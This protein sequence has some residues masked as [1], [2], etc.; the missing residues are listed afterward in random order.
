MWEKNVGQR[1]VLILVVLLAALALIRDP[2]DTLRPGLDIAGGVSLVFEI[3]DRGMENHPNLAEDMKRLLQQRV[4]PKGV[5]DLT[6]RVHGRN[7]IE[8]Q[9]PLP[10][11]RVAELRRQYANALDDLFAAAVTRG[12]LEEALAR[13]AANRPAVLDE[14]ARGSAERRML[15]VRAAEAY[16][17]YVAALEAYRA[18]P[19]EPVP[20]AA[21]A[22]PD[23]PEAAAAP[24][25]AKTLAD[26]EFELRDAEEALEDAYERLLATN[27][28]R[29]H[30][31]RLLEMEERTQKRD[32]G[33]SELRGKYPELADK[34]NAAVVAH[35]AWRKHRTQLD[36]PADLQRLVRGAGVLEFRILLRPD[37]QNP[38]EF[39]SYRADLA[40]RGPRPVPGKPYGWFKVDN[41]QNFFGLRTL[42][43]VERF[44]PRGDPSFVAEKL[45][46]DYYVLAKLSPDDGLL[47][48]NRD[49]Q[50]QGARPDRDE[51]GRPCVHFQLDVVGG[52]RF[53]NLTRRNIGQPLGILMDDIAYSAPNI[54]TKIG[55]QG[56]IT[57]EFSHDKVNYL[58]QTMNAG[59][60]PARLKDT[61]ISER[62]IGSSLGETNLKLAFRAGVVGVIVVALVMAVYYMSSG[63]VA[64]VALLLNIVLVLAVM[65]L[66]QARLTLAGIAGIILTI[67]MSVDAN[68]LIFERMREERERGS[69]L[70]L[71]IKNGYEKALSTIV[72]ANITTMLTCVILF[73]VGSEEIKGFGLTLGW[74]IVISMF[75]ALFVTRTIFTLLIKYG[76]L[77]SVPMLR[78]IG[79]P[80]VDWYA[81]R[82][83]FIPLSLVLVLVG[84]GLLYERGHRNFLDVE[85]LGGV[86]AE[87]ELRPAPDGTRTLDDV[88]I[89]GLLRNV[90]QNITAD[91]DKL[92]AA[93]VEPVVGLANAFRI[94]VPGVSSER[95]AAMLAEPLEETDRGKNWRLRRDGLDR[96][97]E[98]N[99]VTVRL[100]GDEVSAGDLQVFVRGLPSV[101]RSAGN[102]IAAASVRSI[103]E[104]GFDVR[105]SSFWNITTTEKNRG[106]VQH[107]LEEALGDHLERQRRV[108]HIFRGDELGRPFPIN[109][110]RLENVIAV[111]DF[112]A[113]V[114]AE[115]LTDYL[116]GAAMYFDELD[117]PQTV[118][119]RVT[120][121]V[122]D[123]LRNMRLQPGYQ[124]FPYRRFKVIGVRPAL[125]DDGLPR[126]D[127]AQ[128]PLY[129]SIVVVVVDEDYRFSDNP[130]AWASDFAMKEYDLATAALDTEQSL[131]K[132]SQFKP[133]IAA[134]ST[135]RASLALLLS[136]SM[137]IGYL[138]IRFGRPAYGVAGVAALIHDVCIALAFVGISGFIGGMGHPIGA[139]FLI[140]DFKIDMTIVAA[141]LTIVGYSIND[142]IVV[143][144]RIRETRG[145]LGR[146]TPEIINS[147]IN[148]CMSRTLMTSATTFII[149]LIMYI[150][151]GSSIRGF[152]FCMMVGV[153]TGTY[154]SIAV[155]APLLMVRLSR[156]P[157]PAPVPA[158]A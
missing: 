70:R 58:V 77:K 124:D 40:E 96:H 108:D 142:T 127:S 114:A 56:R 42:G 23:D 59:S 72:D 107:A 81:K 44:D 64:N 112:P 156:E 106:L 68:V 71:I 11:A 1:V 17:A 105:A 154:S 94:R 48:A 73:Y 93:E 75:T 85:F 51:H 50:L 91:A 116:G 138:W 62:T 98:E 87:F 88:A 69:S 89:A 158:S 118:D 13:P 30:F 102:N 101:I 26:L 78:L 5:Y 135:Q 28:D 155:A 100:Q 95:L 134:Q 20:D 34:L 126:H 47:A 113:G 147:S 109:D 122:S 115:P 38:T 46:N 10:P 104:A 125:D 65:A 152:N 92:A 8:I 18:G 84:L 2:R 74:G 121:S 137:I 80:R 39:D 120:G 143:F 79:V 29:D 43:E 139:F 103:V 52:S 97:G 145:R 149:L 111:R 82:K 76:V 151:G 130:V 37:P 33:L 66:L 117:P 19:A 144:D 14:L 21:E 22:D 136:W 57:G 15:A 53:E 54:Q 148:Q 35:D 153:L 90:G 131:R 9:M 55:M 86:S 49:W 3:D 24:A 32:D 4:D 133:Q 41:P 67:G 12:Q 132:V 16:D 146:V 119:P 123:R 27:M 157:R 61:P 150:F 128:N 25:P 63:L 110:R 99:V 6:W 7:R 83:F 36:G 129:R 31:M 140:D 60:L 141:F 45:G